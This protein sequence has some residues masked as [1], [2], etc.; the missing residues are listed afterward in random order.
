MSFL[1]LV[2]ARE[3]FDR[4]CDRYRADPL[5]D[6]PSWVRD[7]KPKQLLSGPTVCTGT[8]SFAGVAVRDFLGRHGNL[9]GVVDD[10]RGGDTVGGH[11]Q[12]RSAD[13]ATLLT[14]HPDLIL[15]NT[16]MTEKGRSYFDRLAAQA[17]L[18]TLDAL[19]FHR[20]LWA[21]DRTRMFESDPESTLVLD[22]PLYSFESTLAHQETLRKAE[23]YYQDT[24]S[25][26]T[27][28]NLLL[29]RLTFDP[30]RIARVSVG[31][32]LAPYGPSSYIFNSSFFRFS[33]EET[34]V[35]AGAYRG[36]TVSLFRQ[37]VKGK[38]RKIH[39]FEPDSVNRAY[40]EARVLEEFGADARV[41]VHAAGLWDRGGELQLKPLDFGDFRR[42]GSYFVPSASRALGL[43]STQTVP[44][45]ALDEVVGDQPVTFL[46]LE[47]EGSE[48]PALRGARQ[49]ILR[50]RPKLSLAA[51]HLPTDLFTLPAFVDELGCGYTVHLC[52]HNDLG[53]TNT[54]CYAVP[55]I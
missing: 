33:D 27:F 44:V 38:F 9:L 21:V 28:Y 34:F 25:R 30:T 10:A 39:A 15:V 49:S 16:A 54:V 3:T 41:E 19:Q 36:E 43:A 52:H 12:L 48:I 6:L 31:N 50:G 5:A 23:G 46:K 18:R 55:P 2:T 45:V 32:A 20:A 1:D 4:L 37:A 29:F 35:D 8:T 42:S 26:I 40:C 11:P 53:D 14:R 13:L 22:D 7:L 51:Y 24:Y 17:G 47:I